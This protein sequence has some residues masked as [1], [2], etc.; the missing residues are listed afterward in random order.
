M[1][2]GRMEKNVTAP[3]DSGSMHCNQKGTVLQ[4][5]VDIFSKDVIDSIGDWLADIQGDKK[6]EEKINKLAKDLLDHG[7][8]KTSNEAYE[9]ARKIVETK[10]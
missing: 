6:R 3:P 2:T 7:F 8:A 10:K 9:R 5:Q 4:L 1:K